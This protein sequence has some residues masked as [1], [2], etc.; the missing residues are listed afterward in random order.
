MKQLQADMP[1]ASTA[2]DA[3]K[4]P[5]AY[6][7]TEVDAVGVVACLDAQQLFANCNAITIQH[8]GEIYLLSLTRQN[9]LL[10]TKQAEKA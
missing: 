1:S 8:A 5:H 2:I 7:A 3:D 9:K 4:A 10:L 6:V